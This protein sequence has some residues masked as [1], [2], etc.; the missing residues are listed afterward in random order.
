VRLRH[1]IGLCVWPLAACVT[2]PQ[3]VVP[4]PTDVDIQHAVMQ[5]RDAIVAAQDKSKKD[6]QYAGMYP[7]TAQA[8]FNVTA[9]ANQQNTIVLDAAIKPPVPAS[10]SLGLS[11]SYVAG[12]NASRGN[13]ITITFASS[14]CMTSAN[15]S[16]A[17]SATKTQTAPGKSGPRPIMPRPRM[18]QPLHR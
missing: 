11:D 7:C 15:G 16:A 9:S 14:L 3:Q 18:M 17:G 2:Q 1:L 6:Q 5:I 10:P 12:A 8:V 13:Q 4:R